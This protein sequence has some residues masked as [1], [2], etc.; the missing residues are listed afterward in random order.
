MLTVTLLQSTP[1]QHTSYLSI[2]IADQA[3]L[4]IFDFFILSQLGDSYLSRLSSLFG[5]HFLLGFSLAVFALFAFGAF[6]LVRQFSIQESAQ[7]NS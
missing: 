5:A 6:L 4:I 7:A 2:L 1:V 3:T